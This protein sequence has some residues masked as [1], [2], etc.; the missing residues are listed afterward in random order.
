MKTFHLH[1][2]HV[3]SCPWRGLV[4]SCW[5]QAS[6]RQAIFET[7]TT[8]GDSRFQFLTGDKVK[9]GWRSAS[10]MVP[11]RRNATWRM[12]HDSVG[13]KGACV[14][15]THAVTCD[16]AST[17]VA[18]CESLKQLIVWVSRGWNNSLH[19]SCH[20]ASEGILC[21]IMNVTVTY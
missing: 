15:I 12:E 21:S 6:S 2:W 8:C 9:G 7:Q 5:V 20:S 13:Y 16:A 4:T 11:F 17:I 3:W 19:A 10:E 14:C 18:F 1:G